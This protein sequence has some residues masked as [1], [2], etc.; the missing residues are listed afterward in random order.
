M[1]YNAAHTSKIAANHISN[2]ESRDFPA[3]L[4]PEL[5]STKDRAQLHACRKLNALLINARQTT[6]KPRAAYVSAVY[7]LI[8]LHQICTTLMQT[9]ENP[10]FV[11]IQE[12]QAQKNRELA[13]L[14]GGGG[15]AST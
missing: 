4:C 7:Q 12:W 13:R 3:F 10:C 2:H 15:I 5:P 14:F 8:R 11:D 6:R 1:S 9:R